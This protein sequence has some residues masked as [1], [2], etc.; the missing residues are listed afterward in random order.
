[1][2]IHL[3]SQWLILKKAH[4]NVY[5][6]LVCLNIY[7]SIVCVNLYLAYIYSCLFFK[8]NLY[9][10]I[11]GLKDKKMTSTKIYG[12]W[13]RECSSLSHHRTIDVWVDSAMHN[14]TMTMK[15]WCIIAVMMVRWRDNTMTIV[16]LQDKAIARWHYCTIGYGDSAIAMR[17]W[18]NDKDSNL[19]RAIVM[20]L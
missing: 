13:I 3:T 5:L 9:I 12:T 1:M 2:K 17:Q 15:R 16:W 4:Y 10:H 19:S 11:V 8:K 20:T 6:F 18:C 14:N 7:M